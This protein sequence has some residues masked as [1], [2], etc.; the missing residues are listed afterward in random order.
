MSHYDIDQFFYC[1]DPDCQV[2]ETVIIEAPPSEPTLDSTPS[3]SG[4]TFSEPSYFKFPP[5][6]DLGDLVSNMSQTSYLDDVTNDVTEDDSAYLSCSSS[7]YSPSIPP[8][9]STA[10]SVVSNSSH[11]PSFLKQGLQYTIQSRRLQKGKGLLEVEFK[12]PEPE[13]VSTT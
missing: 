13:K 6:V 7:Q 10:S 1:T 3:T 4:T 11:I 8:T 9:P 2:A 12:E 5:T